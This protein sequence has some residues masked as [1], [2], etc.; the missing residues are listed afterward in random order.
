[1]RKAANWFFSQNPG[2]YILI[3]TLVGFFAVWEKDFALQQQDHSQQRLI[4]SENMIRLHATEFQTYAAAFVSAVLKKS[5]DLEKHRQRLKDNIN[6]QYATADVFARSFNE[7]TSQ[8]V[9]E[10]QDRLST[11]RIAVDQ[12]HDVLTMRNFW[13]SASDLLVARNALLDR[14]NRQLTSPG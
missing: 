9:A 6:S 5:T 10:F 1:M 13:E 3:V 8:A 14:V 2:W 11:M 4:Y 12:V 7:E